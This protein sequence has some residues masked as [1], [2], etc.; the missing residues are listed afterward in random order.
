MRAVQKVDLPAP[1]GPK[2]GALACGGGG[3][4]TSGVRRSSQ[5]QRRITKKEEGKGEER[6][7]ERG[8]YYHD[9]RANLLM[10]S[11]CDVQRIMSWQG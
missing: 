1:L 10:F 6:K 3:S 11:G 9:Q 7:R 8:Q 2:E 4:K 5:T